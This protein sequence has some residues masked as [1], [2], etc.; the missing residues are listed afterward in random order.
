MNQFGEL[1]SSHPLIIHR[2]EELK[3]FAASPEYQALQARVG[4]PA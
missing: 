2:I 1:L 3:R 4:M